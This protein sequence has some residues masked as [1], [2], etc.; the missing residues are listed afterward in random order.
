METKIMTN[1][2]EIVK[3]TAKSTLI[4][5][6]TGEPA[7]NIELINFSFFNS[8]EN[9][10]TNE[11]GFNIVSQKDLYQIG[12]RA[13]YVQPDYCVPDTE[14]F[15]SFIAPN[16][17]PKKSKLGKNNRIKA[18]KFNFTKEDNCD[19]IYSNG[20]LLPLVSLVDVILPDSVN[21]LAG[22]L[23]IIKYEE[24][25]RF[26][27]GRVKGNLPG[28]LY[29]TDEE[30]AANLKSY[31]NRLLEVG[32]ELVYTLK[33][34]GSSF[35]QY[36]MRNEGELVTGICSRLLEKK[37]IDDP[38]ND[39]RWVRLSHSSGLYERGM[40]YCT[41]YD[42]QLAFRGEMY[43]LEATKGSGN[44][45]NPHANMYPDLIIFGID[46]LDTG[47][48]VRL[49]PD[50]VVS[51]CKDMGVDYLVPLP[52]SASNYGELIS[53]ANE[54]FEEYKK[55]YDWI[56]EGIVVRTRNNNKLSCKILNDFYDTKK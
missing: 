8:E 43:G 55:I 45:L 51:I 44:K 26:G 10:Y 17:D 4:K 11:C 33:I 37:D 31:I 46:D 48:A 50:E 20:I 7:N 27:N 1:P 38:N 21:D 52:I 9:D 18:I 56:I 14:L 28:F 54:I 35:T 5:K 39:D 16:G 40:R 13:V 36:F 47:R 23:G 3:I 2:V 49:L 15:S 6:G 53:K 12:D 22:Y 42:R 32:E 41:H 19:V 30:N 24:P 34:D 25:E 29:K